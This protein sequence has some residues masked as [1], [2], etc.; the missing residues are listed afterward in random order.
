MS[1][2]GWKDDDNRALEFP[3][4]KTPEVAPAESPGVE[5]RGRLIYSQAAKWFKASVN[6]GP[7]VP[8]AGGSPQAAAESAWFI[9]PV[10]GDDNNSGTVVGKPLKTHEEL[11]GRIGSQI[12]DQFTT[13]SL[14]NDFDSDNPVII[15]FTIGRN[16]GLRYVGTKTPTALYT[17]IAGF[18]DV[19]P[20]SA[21]TNQ[22]QEVED[23]A[24]PVG[25]GA[26][27]LVNTATNGMIRIRVTGGSAIGQVSW[28]AK[29]LGVFVARTSP[30]GFPITS[31]APSSP[32]TFRTAPLAPPVA[33][34][35][36]F[37]VET[38]FTFVTLLNVDPVFLGAIAGVG[39]FIPKVLFNDLALSSDDDTPPL[40]AAHH[41]ETP[42]GVVT[43]SGCDSGALEAQGGGGK[44]ALEFGKTGTSGTTQPY[45]QNIMQLSAQAV[46]SDVFVFGFAAFINTNCLFQAA[47]L[48]VFSRLFCASV[49][50]MD[51]IGPAGVIVE[52]TAL[53]MSDF[54]ADPAAIYGSG[55]VAGMKIRPGG[56]LVYPNAGQIPSINLGG[57]DEVIIGSL[58]PTTWAAVV[59]GP[60]IVDTSTLSA[61]SLDT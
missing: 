19:T 7:Y 54:V 4:E 36:T 48:N 1:T 38:G 51:S 30:F 8:L 59:A 24:I 33:I 37:V 46:F 3:D 5:G 21:P 25:W 43:F 26:A 49:C 6:G 9:D 29:D 34:G 44:I 20:I 40:V 18:T 52:D 60:S 39:D 23:T 10:A 61:A 41:F 56:Q 45:T 15:D 27:G 47:S 35:D 11:R 28:A 16:G 31:F 12:I 32:P 53:S 22:P 14:A 57:P 55:N 17:S 50:V 13:I 2:W 42:V 58:A